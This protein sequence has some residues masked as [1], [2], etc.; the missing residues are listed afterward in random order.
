MLTLLILACKPT[1]IPT[2]DP[3]PSPP[4]PPE[5]LGI[6]E[7]MADNRNAFRDPAGVECAE[8]DDWIE[9]VNAA[10]TPVELDGVVLEDSN[11]SWA[12]PSGTLAPG[13]RLLIW[14]DDAV[15]QGPLHASLKV[16]K[17]GE[18]LRL[19]QGT[20]VLDEVV[21]PPL[22]PNQ[23]W[24]RTS[25]G[26][27]TFEISDRPT[28]GEAN[29][30][31]VP[32][33][34]CFVNPDFDDH[35]Y[36]CITDEAGYLW[37]A[38]PRTDLAVV[39]FDVFD[40]QS[41]SARR[42]EFMDSNFYTLHDQFYI[43]TLFNGHPFGNLDRFA[44]YPGNFATWK[45]LED[46][47]LTMDLA[48]FDPELIRFSQGR[49]FSRYFYN[50]I[51]GVNRDLGVGTLV[52]R[53]AQGDREAFWGF[54]LESGDDITQ[55]DL[56]IYFDVLAAHGN[57][58][59]AGVV[60]L[61]RSPAQEA[62]AQQME[63][64]GHPLATR[65]LRYAEL[66]EPGEVQVYNPGL[67]AGRV[68]MVRTGEDGLE[69][70]REDTILVL[71]EV[72][73]YLP[74]ARAL[75]TN[76]QQTPLSHV[77]L[78]ARSRGIPNVHLAGVTTDAQ[79]DAWARVSARVVLEVTEDALRVADL[80]QPAYD[81]WLSLRASTPP[82]IVPVDGS[83]LPYGVAL[84]GTSEVLEL[85]RTAGGKVAG[86]AQLVATG[87]L[88]VPD[89]PYGI[90][91]RT[92]QQH[93][94][95]LPSP[96][97]LGGPT[98]LEAVL[99]DH[100]FVRTT[101]TPQRYMVIEGID[102]YNDRYT[103]QADADR[104]QAFLEQHPPGDQAGDLVRNGG[105]RHLVET[106][107][108][109]TQAADAIRTALA[110]RYAGYADTGLRF[111]SSSTVEDIE[112]F[113]GAGLYGSFTGYFDEANGDPID[114]A[115]RRVFGSYWGYEAVE[116]RQ[117][118]GVPHLAGAMGILVHPRFEDLYERANMVL[119]LT[120]FGPGD[121]ELL[122]NAQA[123]ATSVANPPT[124]CPAV[125]P[126]QVRVTATTIERL[127][128]STE[129]TGDVLSD[130]ELRSL[131]DDAVAVA[132]G[133]LALENARLP[134]ERRREVL[135]L[136]LEARAMEPGWLGSPGERLVLK[137]SRSLD[138]STSKLPVELRTLPAP[139]DLLAR[140]SLIQRLT[141]TGDDV[142]ATLDSLQTDP[143]QPPDVGWSMS[144]YVFQVAVEVLADQPELGW[145]TGGFVSWNHL[146]L[147]DASLSGEQFDALLA[148]GEA[149]FG[150]LGWSV[151]NATG[152]ASGGA[153]VCESTI[154]WSSPEAFLLEQLDSAP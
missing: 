7:V 44:P 73:D 108:L 111:R 86:M 154:V 77:A 63:A 88:D 141:C 23:S 91:V 97:G 69:N 143:L 51:N 127:A 55:A 2:T 123:G 12:L 28:P 40:F 105:L 94:E 4:A 87:G 98:W 43:F 48:V 90:T 18:T 99:D 153:L 36:A 57:P 3:P 116:E 115:V 47:A 142:V 140:A 122:V 79:W 120:R 25:D 67:T 118:A 83:T 10:A 101:D 82:T 130:A 81:T 8:Y 121:H 21:V 29:G 14:A 149:S 56:E 106:T 31:P 125:L 96:N 71:D 17:L 117:Q 110:E 109:P 9:L 112:G 150:P 68:K 66:S 131:Y 137:Q 104:L 37:L 19:V 103:T 85:R 70:S 46:W 60:W 64:A 147:T 22:G 114:V 65:F 39:K 72:P 144:P 80:E 129:T 45:A 93:L 100:P 32:V 95:A 41:P 1:P 26:A 113:N 89:L 76:V 49:L 78:L 35:A 20:A 27:G 53:V 58:E 6:N 133:W 30:R 50:S 61:I 33:D 13:E 38:G 92:Y 75:I 52:H 134:A 74:P 145:T 15:E 119:T 148:D 62:L 84:D 152:T 128:Q 139:E 124:V 126:E 54:E 59:L 102:A 5:G 136:D 146:D 151:T 11:S 24:A 135:T 138:P 16:S 42:I 132:E 34:P 107:P